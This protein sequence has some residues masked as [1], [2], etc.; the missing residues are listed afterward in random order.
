MPRKF[1]VKRQPIL[2]DSH[3]SNKGNRKSTERGNLIRP[4][5][6]EGKHVKGRSPHRASRKIINLSSATLENSPKGH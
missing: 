6:R 5:P 1:F 4:Q 3:T 2:M